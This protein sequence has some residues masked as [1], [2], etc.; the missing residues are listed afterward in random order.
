LKI[1]NEK[2]KNLLFFPLFFVFHLPLFP[3]RK[4]KENIPKL[5]P[6]L[7]FGLTK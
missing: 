4:N 1:E 3:S 7:L 2:L 5:E 6:L